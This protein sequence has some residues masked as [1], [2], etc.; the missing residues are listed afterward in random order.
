M[1][2]GDLRAAAPGPLTPATGPARRRRTPWHPAW[3]VA[4]ITF[5]ALVAA[6]AFR[7]STGV[8]I[9]P[10]EAEFGWSR[11]WTSSAV[12]IN[13]VLFGVTAPFAAA[14]MDRFGVRKVVAIALTLTAL[15]SGLTLVMT[16]A[17]QL[18][19]LWGLVVGLGTGSMA[20]VFG[21]IV[22]NRWFV[23]QRGLVMGLFSAGSATGQLVVLPV[24]AWLATHAGW[25]WAAALT[26]GL[27]LAL[28]P[29]V[30]L[31]LRERPSDLG[32]LP[33]GATEPDV[34]PD[35][36]VEPAAETPPPTADIA[37]VQI[38]EPPADSPGRQALSEL[39]RATHS[40]AFWVLAATFFVCGWSTNGLIQ[41][42][43]VPMAMDHG[44]PEDT[45]AG[46]LA[47]VGIFD[48]VGTTAS[49]WLSDRVDARILLFVY[50][51]L[52]GLALLAGPAVMSNRV[53]P[54][55][56]F[57][58]VFYGLDWVATVPPTVALCRQQFGTARS[59]IVF[60]W[61]FAAHM[62]GA[63]IAAEV[64][65]VIRASTGSYDDAWWLAGGLCLVA[66]VSIFTLR[67]PGGGGAVTGGHFDGPGKAGRQRRDHL[68]GDPAAAA[69][70]AGA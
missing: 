65:G 15:G 45:A 4:G 53:D 16:Q 19:V 9:E 61:V 55:L 52:R 39:A 41:T 46:L 37:A 34:E 6:A 60:G 5:L 8:L 66:A 1:T 13:L 36:R 58:I 48:I 50:Y 2:A 63:G 26:A 42:H 3:T 38:P 49:G 64:A 12:S 70:Q 18:L 56:L 51:G 54:P 28:V 47:V 24:V 29:V 10:V 22:A 32:L 31:F 59:G 23:A 20:L 69:D 68:R 7:S 35:N 25:R 40:P 21:A 11:I 44:M 62:V 14:L 43:F 57:F 33:Y 67:V 17:W 30:G 27:A